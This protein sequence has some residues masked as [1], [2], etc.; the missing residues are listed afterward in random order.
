MGSPSVNSKLALNVHS[1]QCY[2]VIFPMGFKQ[3]HI[4]EHNYTYINL[5]PSSP[6]DSFRHFASNDTLF[7]NYIN[8][9]FLKQLCQKYLTG[10]IKLFTFLEEQI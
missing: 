8:I 5:I 9:C 4:T 10:V 6:F 7:H 2:M 3:N 1:I